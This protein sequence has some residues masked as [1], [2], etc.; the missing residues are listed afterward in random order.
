MGMGIRGASRRR[1]ERARRRRMA[2]VASAAMLSTIA[3]QAGAQAEAPR[4]QGSGERPQTSRDEEGAPTFEL[5]PTTVEGERERYFVERPSSPR[6]TEPL[7]ETPQS[8]TVVPREVFE[9]QGATSIRDVLR[10][11]PGIT[12]AAGEG[13]GPQGDNLRIRGFAANTDLF[14]DGMRDLSQY[15]RDP[16]FIESIEVSKGPGSAY[17]GRGST[18][19]VVNLV[20]KTANLGNA[21]DGSV[22]AGTNSQLRFAAD[23]NRELD[24][25][26]GTAVRLNAMGQR[27]EVAGRD[28][29]E[30]DRWGIFPTLAVGLGTPTRLTA[31]YLHLELDGVADYGHPFVDG[32]PVDVRRS[33]FYGFADL[34]FEKTEV[35]LATFGAEH[36]LTD[37][38][39]IR[40]QF[41]YG[42][43]TRD[44]IVTPPRNANAETDEVTINLPARDSGNKFLLNQL[45]ATVAADTAGFRHTVVAGVEVGRE[46]YD[47]R[48]F[49]FDGGPFTDSL[50]DPDPFRPFP[51]TRIAE[52]TADR[53]AKADILGLYAFDTIELGEWVEVSGGL[54]WDRFDAEVDNTATGDSFDRTDEELTYRAGVVGKILPTA[55]VYAAYGTSFNPSAEQLSLTESTADVDPEESRTYEVGAKWDVDRRLALT[56]A[57]FRIEKTDARTASLVPDDPV[58]VLDGEQRV[59]GFEIGAA[60]SLTDDWWIFGGYA[61]LDSEIEESNVAEEVGKEVI[62]APEHALSVWT[63]YAFP[64]GVE[65]GFGV[66]YVSSKYANATNT[67]RIDDS[68]LFD[69]MLGY[70]A[71]EHVAFR[72]NVFNLGDEFYYDRTH[73]QHAVPGPGRSALFT[74]TVSF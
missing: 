11:V 48:S 13:G 4:G 58:Q 19:G 42:D 15:T 22:A 30:D 9:D 65:G 62:N 34:A 20:S 50:F 66:Q 43:T 26:E 54:R 29:I 46:E 51:G 18:G 8:I 47:F 68:V 63:T 21:I 53:T 6:R 72:V 59:D 44:A 55:N 23:A 1:L 38:V 7:R 3:A 74:T 2:A 57:L 25:F 35:D 16:F 60:G 14:L 52:P 37:E 67:N 36:D 12:L 56:G 61:W 45:D 5:D 10:G 24:V 40:N 31:S 69:A 70:R 64:W 49:A 33:A 17:A 41:R 39:M 73:P 32:E 27:A 71:F 28:V